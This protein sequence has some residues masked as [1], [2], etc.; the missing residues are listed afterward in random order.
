MSRKYRQRGYQDDNSQS[1]E[2]RSQ[3][4]PRKASREGPRSPRMTAFQQVLRCGMCGVTLP[5]DFTEIS[6]SSTCPKCSADLHTCKNCLF[7]DPASQF[8]CTKPIKERI[9]PKDQG[10]WCQ[11]FEARTRVEKA[12]GSAPA[13]QQ[14]LDPREAFER[15]FKK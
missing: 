7:F 6:V 9:S 14:P 3:Q 5:P 8:E 4:A 15:L 13:P 12:T 2:G 10:N 11:F 1:Q